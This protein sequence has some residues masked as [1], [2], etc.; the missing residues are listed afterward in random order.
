MGWQSWLHVMVVDYTCSCTSHSSMSTA[1]LSGSVLPPGEE[2]NIGRV[3]FC[4][5]VTAYAQQQW[6]F[7]R[8]YFLW[9]VTA[10]QNI[11]IPGINITRSTC[12]M[13]IQQHIHHSYNIHRVTYTG[14]VCELCSAESAREIKNTDFFCALNHVAR[15]QDKGN[16]CMDETNRECC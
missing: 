8:N 13:Q 14:C 4:G 16:S 3:S 7:T 5:T 2:H 6:I 1:T 12:G 10:S 15:G 9:V 11:T